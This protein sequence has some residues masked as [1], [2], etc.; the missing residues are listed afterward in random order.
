MVELGKNSMGTLE[1]YKIVAFSIYFYSTSQNG[2]IQH[3]I[4]YVFDI[5]EKAPR[6]LLKIVEN[7]L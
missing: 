6:Y 2:K 7:F 4:K 5:Y 1:I 3:Y